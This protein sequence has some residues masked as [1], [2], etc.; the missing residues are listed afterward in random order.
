M[1][2]KTLEPSQLVV[3]FRTRRGIA[4]G[5]IEASDENPID[6]RLDVPAMNVLGVA[7]QPAT[8]LE[9]IAPSRQ[10]G[11]AVP[12]FLPMPDCAVA[13]LPNRRFRKFFLRCLQL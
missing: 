13:G 5:K 8:A 7:R 6:T 1:L 2:G 4:V 10:D 11:D 9:G 12:A 3:E